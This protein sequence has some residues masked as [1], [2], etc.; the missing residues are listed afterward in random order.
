M[1]H[2][3]FLLIT[4]LWTTAATAQL[5]RADISIVRGSVAQNAPPVYTDGWIMQQL[6][7]GDV[8]IASI[9]Q[10]IINGGQ[11]RIFIDNDVEIGW[12]TAS[13]LTFHALN[14]FKPTGNSPN[15]PNATRWLLNPTAG[16][17]IIIKSDGV[18][19]NNVLIVDD[20]IGVDITG[21]RIISNG[22]DLG[23][24][25]IVGFTFGT[26]IGVKMSNTEIEIRDGEL[27][28][29]SDTPQANSAS[30]GIQITGSDVSINVHNG[31][32]TILGYVMNMTKPSIGLLVQG[33]LDIIGHGDTNLNLIAQVGGGAGS[34][35]LVVTDQASISSEF[36][37]VQ[38]GSTM[39]TDL[40]NITG[41][42]ISNQSNLSGY[43]L[44]MTSSVG[45]TGNN[46]VAILIEESI[47]SFQSNI[48]VNGSA[49]AQGD[50]LRGIVVRNNAEITTPRRIEILGN[51][52]VGGELCIGV[53]IHSAPKALSSTF[54]DIII[55]G[56]TYSMGEHNVGVWIAQTLQQPVFPLN[57][58]GVAP[59]ISGDAIIKALNGPISIIGT[60]GAVPDSKYGV[61]ITDGSLIH[62]VRNNVSING[63]TETIGTSPAGTAS[64]F[65]NGSTIIT[66]DPQN[67]QVSG[68][69]EMSGGESQQHDKFIVSNARIE[70]LSSGGIRL[71]SSDDLV[72]NGDATVRS[73]SGNVTIVVDSR[74]LTSQNPGPGGFYSGSSTS[75]QALG[76]IRIY[77]HR[78]PNNQILGKINGL[79][80]MPGIEYLDSSAEQWN[81]AF[82]NGTY[83]G[84]P[85]KIYYHENGQAQVVTI[86]GHKFDDLNGNGIKDQNEPFI[87]GFTFYVDLNANEQFDQGE[88]SAVSD[89]NGFFEIINIPAGTFLVR[90][91]PIFAWVQ[92]TP[93]GGQG[94]DGL[95]VEVT[96]SAGQSK[97]D[98]LFGNRNLFAP[99]TSGSISGVV[100]NDIDKNGQQDQGEPELQGWV[101]YIDNN[102]NG[103]FDQGEPFAVTNASGV[104]L[105]D[106]M[107]FQGYSIR[108]NVMQGW[109][110][111]SPSQQAGFRHAL[112]LNANAPNA[113][114]LNFGVSQQ[115]VVN[116]FVTVS[117]IVFHD[118]NNNGIRD[119]GEPGVQ[120]V[121]IYIDSNTNDAFDSGELSDLTDADGVFFIDQ[122]PEGTFLVRANLENGWTQTFP[123]GSHGGDGLAFELTLMGGD[124]NNDLLFGK[125]ESPVPPGPGS[126]SGY[127]YYNYNIDEYWQDWKSDQPTRRW[128]SVK[129]DH[130]STSGQIT[131]S[132][133]ETDS[134]GRFY[135]DN[136][137]AGEYWVYLEPSAYTPI[138]P[139]NVRPATTSI[140]PTVAYR[141]LLQPGQHFGVDRS[142]FSF[143]P[144][145]SSNGWLRDVEER[146]DTL[147]S[148]MALW[149]DVDKDGTPDERIQF[150]GS[151][152]IHQGAPSSASGKH[153]APLRIE[154]L[155]MSAW[156]AEYG[157]VRARLKTGS[158][159]TGVVTQS[160]NADT[161]FVEMQFDVVIYTQSNV[162]TGDSSIELNGTTLRMP[163]INGRLIANLDTDPLIYRN[164]FGAE[165]FRVH[166]VQFIA[167][168][169]A[170]FGTIRADFGDAP[171]MYGTLLR[172]D[173]MLWGLDGDVLRRKGDGARHIQT[174]VGAPTLYLGSNVITEP[175]GKPS[176]NA[177]LDND[178][179]LTPVTLT[180][181][182][183]VT[184]PIAIIGEGYLTIWTDYNGSGKF[185]DQSG[186]VLRDAQ[187][188]TGT[189]AFTFTPS[190][191]IPGD[192]LFIRIRLS[193]TP[194]V[195]S[196]GP[197][198]EGEVEDY[199]FEVAPLAT[200]WTVTGV[201][202]DDKNG[203]NNWEDADENGIEGIRVF[204]DVNG[205][206]VYDAGEP[207]A[208]TDVDGN[209]MLTSDKSGN[210]EII[211]ET[212][213]N[214]SLPNGFVYPRISLSPGVNSGA[215]FPFRRLTTSI[216][217]EA[218]LP[219]AFEL[220]S[221]WPNPFNPTTNIKFSMPA[222][223]KVTIAM[224]D[225]IGRV[226]K[227]LDL[228]Q[229]Q[230]G[231]HQVTIDAH[232][233]PSG[234]YII[235]MKSGALSASQKVSLIK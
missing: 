174:Y 209:Y 76:E 235:H 165:S 26:N 75:I 142:A 10:P 184:I 103:Q 37:N 41:I 169:G 160:A 202:Y 84:H 111:T 159:S 136:L 61:L 220:L 139:E 168:Y 21:G 155:E 118:L 38:V 109:E 216:G 190:Y 49:Q 14:Y 87:A 83:G 73:N 28:V 186:V 106:N 173:K 197:T 224:I 36:G 114:D 98:L 200:V 42:Q 2:L 210:H 185:D 54:D 231:Y 1:K 30:Y 66:G 4:L 6:A 119:A 134:D 149:V 167:Q 179:G 150:T 80:F 88:P 195:R 207:F 47:I 196:N 93:T 129:L 181:G 116:P 189:F 206:R 24:L 191:S 31:A 52:N 107:P 164:V 18:Q 180:R 131:T 25:G 39:L 19:P 146:T 23:I 77:T 97:N 171:Q 163:I 229:K 96:L 233:L 213:S 15:N 9:N 227:V 59:P 132:T 7:L 57:L 100:W 182:L 133:V 148:S 67:P 35:G 92:T 113:T 79:D 16:G 70:T 226:V 81:T 44:N 72:V 85:F 151:V 105:F 126:I 222:T 192:V 161:A 32:I 198:L 99:P 234:V 183:E 12:N 203:N 137:D 140:V 138:Y 63:T 172:P 68:D 176:A 193:R 147:A 27:Y 178:D 45:N 112:I 228:G 53:L 141:V 143:T 58:Q 223:G 104:Y 121:M 62:A 71:S 156:S 187:V 120:D 22:G 17:N 82:P 135:F 123:I 101:A 211:P 214:W 199:M 170:D 152:V 154:L 51:T 46:H 89:A 128:V 157:D 145:M 204:W 3:L 124:Q 64:L 69:I 65:I 33:D 208:V 78:R 8:E 60:A 40:N 90:E 225:M 94:S 205:N 130:I 158:I 13:I 125:I 55:L 217:D 102:D 194:G 218:Q 127:V 91:A 110:Q 5:G 56:H 144:K 232:G 115:Q 153:S 219:L 86:S 43:L 175:D 29:Q 177:N 230:P 48:Y 74:Y 108:V 122:I 34:K 11:G 20:Q 95:S 188:S 117:G 201:V 50:F 221:A 162:Y 215:M 166:H 212:G